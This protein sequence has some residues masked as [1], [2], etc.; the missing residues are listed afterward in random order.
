MIKKFLIFFIA[1]FVPLTA[2][3]VDGLDVLS[4]SDA[5]LYQQIFK[6]QDKEKIVAAQKLE[7]QL[8]DKLLM[9]EVLYQRFISDS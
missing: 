3:A 6:L 7:S 1:L 9:G 5:S 4:D 8:D 2:F